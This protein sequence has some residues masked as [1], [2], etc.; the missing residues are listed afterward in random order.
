MDNFAKYLKIVRWICFGCISSVFAHSSNVGSYTGFSGQLGLYSRGVSDG[1]ADTFQTPQMTGELAY[2]YQNFYI[3]LSG[4]NVD[5]LQDTNP[6]IY[7]QGGSLELEALMG[8]FHAWSSGWRN[9]GGV[10]YYYYPGQPRQLELPTPPIPDL[11]PGQITAFEL[12]DTV[13]WRWFSFGFDVT[14]LATYFGLKDA[15]GS[16]SLYFAATVPLGTWMPAVPG[17][18]FRAMWG[19]EFFAGTDP[20]NIVFN[21]NVVSGAP[22]DATPSNATLFNF[23]YYLLSISYALPQAFKIGINYTNTIGTNP[24]I[25][26]SQTQCVTPG[27]CGPN[28]INTAAP[29]VVLYVTKNFN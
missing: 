6:S 24:L 12:Y 1:I 4:R 13:S 27:F 11:S 15:T 17:L 21:S 19:M 10:S 25:W 5:W 8:Y 22:Y 26:G 7:V 14:P 2:N 16:G 3:G 18:I 23:Q 20:R 29:A 28:P 9:N